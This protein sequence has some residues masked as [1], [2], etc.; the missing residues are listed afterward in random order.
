VALELGESIVR[1]YP[2]TRMAEETTALLPGIRSKLN[3]V[4][5]AP[6]SPSSPPS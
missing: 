4:A 5:A 2:N 6:S 3:G 1:D